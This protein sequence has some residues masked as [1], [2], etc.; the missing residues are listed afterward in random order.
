MKFVGKTKEELIE[1]LQTIQQ[2]QN[3]LKAL[4]EKDITLLRNAE[5]KLKSNEERQR[6]VLEN[7]VDATYKRNL[8]TNDYEYISPAFFRLTGYT[9][10]EMKTLPL[11][12]VIGLMHPDDMPEVEQTLALAISKGTGQGNHVEYR[13]R[14]KDGEYRWFID[15]FTLLKDI[16]NNPVALIGNISDITER[17]L[18]EE[19]LRVN[20]EKHRI[21]L[22]T[23]MDGFWLADNK[24]RILEVNGTYVQMS[25]YSADEL[26]TM[27]IS[28][29]EVIESEADTVNHFQKILSQGEDRFETRHRRKNGTTYDVEVS[30]Q[31][32]S[33]EGGLFVAF[34]RNITEHKKAEQALTESEEKYRVLLNGSPYGILTT[35]IETQRFL[36]SNPA[37]CKLFGYTDEEFQRLSIENLVPKESL[38]L[39][40]SEFASQMRGDKSVSF[41]QPCRRKDGTIFSADIAGAPIIL[42]GRK[43]SVGFFS[44]VTD[45]KDAEEALK[46]SEEKYRSLF[47]NVQDVFYQ[48]D[49]AGV[50]QDIS[51]SIKHFSKFNRDEIVG[52]NVAD[53]YYNPM[54]RELLL[55]EIRNKGE[56]RDYELILKTTDGEKKF[57]SINASLIFDADG[58]PNHIDGAL[59]DITDRKLAD[60][61]VRL[62]E[63]A[64]KG[65]NAQLIEAQRIARIGSWTHHLENDLPVWSDEMFVIFGIDPRLGV[66]TYPVFRQLV[67]PDQR[68][69]LDDAINAVMTTGHGYSL[70]LRVNLPDENKRI[71]HMQCE[72]FFGT[73]GLVFS[74]LGTAQDI[75]ER[76]QFEMEL[77]V[78]KERAEESDRLKSAFLANMSH[79][80]RTPMNGI[81]GFAELLKETK[82]TGGEQQN[83]ISVIRK[84]G[85]RMLNI[86]NDIVSISQIESG[87]MNVSIS[88]TNVN[89]QIESV[90]TFFT[91]YVE[92]KGLLLSI[93]NTLPSNECRITTDREK[94]Y[95]IL[96]N[97]LGNA[98]KFTSAGSIEFGVEKKGD[99]I[100]FFVKDT[101]CGVNENKKE[102]IFERF[103]QGSELITKPYEGAGLGLSISKGYVEMLGGKIWME[104][105]LGKGSTFY[106]TLPYNNKKETTTVIEDP[107]SGTALTNQAYNLKILIAED[108]ES[109]VHFL[110]MVLR[111][112][113]KKI[114]TAE[115]GVEVV[116]VC[117]ENPDIDLVLMDVRMPEIDGYEATRLI[118][119][120]NKDVII[121]A[122]TAYA[123]VGDR[124]K[125]IKAGCNDHISKPIVIEELKE[126]I[127]KH[128]S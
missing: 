2:E 54:D 110:S 80:I 86:I 112:Y 114:L 34:I 77:I 68:L 27:K 58:K 106:F 96:T 64:L 63:S 24:G 91:P 20:E 60:E 14:H 83:Y 44:D 29:L 1:Q 71:I 41:A 95:A 119:Q 117:R 69:I 104:S 90:Y 75:T 67:D 33:I 17:K 89:E 101:G 107:S 49:L 16:Q 105:E 93:K 21:L 66:P 12:T 47:E 32:K 103:R 11:E 26:V 92:K 52:R 55:N 56:V 7:S 98:L 97:L 79:E 46:M 25:G 115:T 6:E 122:Q 3:E 19:T 30:V 123:M 124:E 38:D 70:E 9:P 78:A 5:E 116:E 99:Y 4:Y 102:I 87:Q 120:F 62:S 128:F 59:R 45:R 121:I 53:I 57:A 22:H 36:F 39:V 42:N 61:K 100:E 127:R 88:A 43:C 15:R 51:P 28:D 82:L 81:L 72:A 31:Y 48:I 118:R 109:S 23:A 8:R 40:M 108:D 111:M 74:T 84:S 76:K 50:I 85:K 113:C 35:D 65:I 10:E 94:L 125:A 126:L 37:I 73:D 13:F 18:A